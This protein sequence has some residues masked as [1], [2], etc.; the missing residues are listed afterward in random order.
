M[1]GNHCYWVVSRDDNFAPF[2]LTCPS[3]LRSARVFPSPQR[4]WGGDGARF[5]PHTTGQGGDGFRLFRPTSPR[6]SPSPSPPRP[7]LLKVIIV[8]F[9]YPK[10][11]L[12]KQTYQYQLILFYLMWFFAFIE[13]NYNMSFFFFFGDCLVKRLDI[14][15]NFF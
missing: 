9:S 12:F 10:I 8:N 5:Q 4:W 2:R 3:P 15:F 6:P 7:A 11:L 1:V 13:T 14:L